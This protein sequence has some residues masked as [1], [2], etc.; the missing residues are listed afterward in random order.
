LICGLVFL[1]AGAL[2]FALATNMYWLFIGR[3]SQGIGVG[4]AVGSGA[5]ALVEY[6]PTS[7]KKLPGSINTIT[8]AVGV[9]IGQ[10]VGAILIK[11]APF[12]LHLSYWV[13]S[14]FVC[15][16]IIFC[17][18]LPQNKRTQSDRKSSWKPAGVRVPSG[19]WGIYILAVL[20]VGMAFSYGGVFL[21]LGA[22]IAREVIGTKDILVIGTV[23][24]ISNLLIAASAT[25]SGRLGPLISIRLG[26]V[27]IML[28][29]VLLVSASELHSFVL[30]MISSILGGIGYGF[31]AA[32]GIALA[33]M[34]SPSQHRAQ[35]LSAV[36]LC[37]L[38]QGASSYGGGVA[39]TAY[40]FS[41]AIKIISVLI[42]LVSFMKL[43]AIINRKKMSSATVKPKPIV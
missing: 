40:G 12:P 8:Q 42:G 26:M 15:V 25:V 41:S 2:A 17:S 16:G 28:T 30:F 10:I 36:F 14:L 19:L 11:Y 13:L 5:A 27:S 6:N 37:Y 3:A 22:Q 21:S 43:L 9:F 35:F 29:F 33:A 20:A 1:L 18:F 4:L 34:N 23:L 38:F 31:S 32:G 39:S 24:S 7:N